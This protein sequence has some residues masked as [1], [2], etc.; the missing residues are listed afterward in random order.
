MTKHLMPI[1]L[2]L[3][4]ALTPDRNAPTWRVAIPV[5]ALLLVLSYNAWEVWGLAQDFSGFRVTPD[6]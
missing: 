3:H 4:L 6:W 1:L 5:A 2:P